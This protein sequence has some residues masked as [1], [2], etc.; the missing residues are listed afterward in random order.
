MTEKTKEQLA[1]D[2][3]ASSKETLDKI[4]STAI[5]TP[6]RKGKKPPKKGTNKSKSRAKK[7]TQ[8]ASPVVNADLVH[9]P[10]SGAGISGQVR[11]DINQTTPEAMAQSLT[12]I[13]QQQNTV[14]VSQANKKLDKQVAIDQGLGLQVELQQQK[15]ATIAE[16]VQTQAMKTQQQATKTSIEGVKLSGLQIDLEGENALLPHRR[17]SWDIKSEEMQIDNEGA[18][19]LLPLRK[20]HWGAKLKLA[21]VGLQKL[22]MQVEREMSELYAPIEVQQLGD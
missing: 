5:K 3:I 14:L 20:E 22:N 7:T 2:I 21:Q 6:A 4:K 11:G 15:N 9:A 1:E 18:R 17:E 19:A 12:A 10:V 8:A 13:A 16:S